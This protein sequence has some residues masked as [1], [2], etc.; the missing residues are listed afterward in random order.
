MFALKYDGKIIAGEKQAMGTSR[1][2]PDPFTRDRADKL[3]DRAQV[4]ESAAYTCKHK[5]TPKDR[6]L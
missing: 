3:P 1:T 4:L 6:D 2:N 5:L